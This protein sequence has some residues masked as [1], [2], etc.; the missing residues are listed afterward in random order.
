MIA[1][2]DP[3]NIVQTVRVQ[4]LNVRSIRTQTV[5]GND[6][7]EVGM[8]LEQLGHKPFSSIA[9]TVIFVRPIVLHDGFWHQGGTLHACPDE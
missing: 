3:K 1:F 9:F 6:E 5:F 8:V 4:R 2:F 7:L